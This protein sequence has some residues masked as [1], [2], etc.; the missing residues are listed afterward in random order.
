MP[1]TILMRARCPSIQSRA[2]LEVL[3]N[4]K[5]LLVR[6]LAHLG[7]LGERAHLDEEGGVLSEEELQTLSDL[8]GIAQDIAEIEDLE[9][10]SDICGACGQEYDLRE[11]DLCT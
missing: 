4:Y 2:L 10:Y 1:L 3:M 11:T 9:A 5:L 6:Y 7:R 8:L